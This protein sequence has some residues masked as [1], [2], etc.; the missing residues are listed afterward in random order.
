MELP[1]FVQSPEPCLGSL[2]HGTVFREDAAHKP[3][4]NSLQENCLVQSREW[5]VCSWSCRMGISTPVTNDSP[6]CCLEKETQLCMV[7]PCDFS[8]EKSKVWCWRRG[9]T[10]AQMLGTALGMSSAHRVC[11]VLPLPPCPIAQRW[12]QSTDLSASFLSCPC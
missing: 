11:S 12:G 4:L 9:D 5:S 10:T 3:E 6:Q 2:P 7:Q 8:V 1:R